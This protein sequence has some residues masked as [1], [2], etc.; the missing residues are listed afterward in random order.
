[1]VKDQEEV[2]FSLVLKIGYRA[3]HEQY[4]PDRLLAHVA[5]A[6]KHGFETLWASDP[7]HPWAHTGA[8]GAGVYK[9]VRKSLK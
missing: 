1:M 4:Q 8:G 9:S 2:N 7:F 6:D 3:C 5:L